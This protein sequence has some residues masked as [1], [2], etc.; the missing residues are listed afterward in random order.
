MGKCQVCKIGKDVELIS[1][2]MSNAEVKTLWRDSTVKVNS[3]TQ[4][5][6]HCTAVLNN[7]KTILGF[8]SRR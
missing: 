6:I 3:E 5:A 2:K 4:I 8:N 1:Y 7:A